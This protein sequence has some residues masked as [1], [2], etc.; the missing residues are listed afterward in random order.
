MSLNDPDPK[1]A[2]AERRGEDRK[3]SVAKA[4]VTVESTYLAGRVENH[5]DGGLFVLVDGGLEV[6]VEWH[7]ETGDHSSS[8]RL[9]R[10]TSLP[11]GRS[12]WGLELTE[13]NPESTHE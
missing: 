13:G 11:G 12:G 9:A 5:S 4:R 2:A 10:V 8:A 1:N 6:K 7:D 3:E